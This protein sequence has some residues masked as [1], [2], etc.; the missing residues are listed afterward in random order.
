MTIANLLRQP[1]LKG[2]TTVCLSLL[3]VALLC[4]CS[5]EMPKPLQMTLSSRT[6]L[7]TVGDTARLNVA[8]TPQA[9][10]SQVTFKSLDETIARVDPTGLIT[11]CASGETAI[12]VALG[13]LRDT[14]RVQVSAQAVAISLPDT[15][16]SVV[17]GD[18]TRIRYT[19]SPEGTPVT[20]TSAAPQVA[21]VDDRGCVRGVSVGETTI[22]LQALST[23]VSVRVSVTAPNIKVSTE[24]PL[25]KFA[26][27]RDATGHITEP[28][29]LSYEQSLGRRSQ[30]IRY[31]MQQT[32]EGFV[33]LDL[34]TIPAVIY[35]IPTEDGHDKRIIAYSKETIAHC[36]R[37]RTMLRSSGFSQIE[38]AV[39]DVAGE[40][41]SVLRAKSDIDPDIT[42]VMMDE[43]YPEFGAQMYMEFVKRMPRHHSI[44]TNV[45]DFPSLKA[46]ATGSLDKAQ[47]FEQ[48]LGLREFSKQDSKHYSRM[49]VT[50]S[51]AL[52]KSNIKWVYY[53][54]RE[55]PS[56]PF[57]NA[58]L[59]CP[60]GKADI[61]STALKEYLA[62]NGFDQE[63]YVDATAN[64]VMVYNH[65]GD[66]CQI[67]EDSKTKRIL[68]QLVLKR[69]LPNYEG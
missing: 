22:M 58:E 20:F 49:F 64:V 28:G 16:I 50:K 68:L 53:T 32:Y 9:T 2:V 57:I 30:S 35:G 4:S 38:S 6:F 65:D 17:E 63:Y 48:Q 39:I 10:S 41:T 55:D 13:S 60:N 23:Q 31:N 67:Y 36:P 19:V 69:D 37:T 43:E 7:L 61:K 47:A 44:M 15:D 5:D 11:A 14:C 46:L 66:L 40:K 45:R 25:M 56:H 34:T 54:L 52:E 3:A 8:I 42:V 18:T 12:A 24:L 62:R 1:L 26:P 27:Q 59:N 29:I 51:E 33:C 21:T